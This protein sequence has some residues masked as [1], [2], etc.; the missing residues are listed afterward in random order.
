MEFH[1]EWF[2]HHL[3]KYPLEPT[4]ID[5]PKYKRKSILHPFCSEKP[6]TYY[7]DYKRDKDQEWRSAQ[8]VG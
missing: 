6:K 8:P 4:I 1:D 5:M 2:V 7:V 3:F